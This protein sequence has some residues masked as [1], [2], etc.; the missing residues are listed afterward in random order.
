MAGAVVGW[1][2]L[3]TAPAGPRA[4]AGP[5]VADSLIGLWIDSVGG[6]DR[7]ERFQSASYTITTILYDTLTG[8]VIRSRPRHV[9]LRKGPNGHQVRVERS[10]PYGSIVQIFD[11]TRGWAFLDGRQLPDTAPDS[12]EVRYVAGDLFYWPGLPYKLRDGGV[13]LEYRGLASRPGA[14]FRAD[15][16]RAAVTPPPDAYHDVRVTFGAG[17]G[18]TQDEFHYY[19]EPGRAFPVE[20]TYVEEREGILNRVLWGET[21]FVGRWRYPHVTRRDWITPSGKRT[22]ALVVDALRINPELSADVFRPLPPP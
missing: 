22:K 6:L 8:R 19:F 2:A 7:Y 21:R 13:F 18:D 3:T 9:W 11:G 12:R 16:R 10:E 15:P 4:P 20:V 17:A 5:Q 14:E 1:A